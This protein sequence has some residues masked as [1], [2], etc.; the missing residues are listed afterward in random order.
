VGSPSVG[1]GS[2]RG[3][4]WDSEKDPKYYMMYYMGLGTVNGPTTT[5][6]PM[7]SEV[8]SETKLERSKKVT[9][10]NTEKQ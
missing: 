4:G 7:C 8:V 10:L 1:E 3:G 6:K 5:S 9:E 2:G